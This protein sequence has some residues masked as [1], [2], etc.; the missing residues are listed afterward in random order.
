MSS[1]PDRARDEYSVGF[2]VLGNCLL[3]AVSGISRCYWLRIEVGAGL[4][5]L[6]VLSLMNS[7]LFVIE[8]NVTLE[9]RCAR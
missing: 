9:M 2:R 5:G 1:G 6:R 3:R 7:F 4:A 8:L